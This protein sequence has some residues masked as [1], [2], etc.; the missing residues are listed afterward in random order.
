[1][2]TQ[3]IHNASESGAEQIC[4]LSL[5]PK[6]C[7]WGATMRSAAGM[8]L[9]TR[10]CPWPYF[11]ARCASL[12]CLET[13]SACCNRVWYA[14]HRPSHL[15][16][17]W[18][19]KRTNRGH[20]ARRCRCLPRGRRVASCLPEDAGPR[21]WSSTRLSRLQAARHSSQQVFAAQTPRCCSTWRSCGVTRSGSMLQ[22][23]DSFVTFIAD[24][25]LRMHA[26]APAG[27]FAARLSLGEG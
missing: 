3:S 25:P 22:S 24:V 26:A 6:L 27:A 1:M 19:V 18:P 5:L 4:S 15:P 13:V 16:A 21:R 10:E 23:C 9:C 2:A 12:A 20:D 14:R 17:D 8:C 7:M 11:G